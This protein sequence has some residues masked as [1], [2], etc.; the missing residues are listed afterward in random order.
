MTIRLVYRDHRPRKI[1]ARASGQTY[2]VDRKGDVIEVA[3]E[4]HQELLRIR[5]GCR[6]RKM[7][8]PAR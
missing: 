6:C 7:F 5:A 4:D 8:A 2:E 1:T 3:D